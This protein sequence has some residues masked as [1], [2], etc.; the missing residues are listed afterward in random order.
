[1]RFFIC[2]TLVILSHYF[3]DVLF[4][5]KY[6]WRAFEFALVAGHR[7]V[8]V[9]DHN[10]K[11]WGWHNKIIILISV[12]EYKFLQLEQLKVGNKQEAFTYSEAN[13]IEWICKLCIFSCIITV[14]KFLYHV[15]VNMSNVVKI[16]SHL[17]RLHDI[18]IFAEVSN[19]DYRQELGLVGL[20]QDA[21]VC[22]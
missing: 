3:L 21:C 22:S 1:M 11:R 19:A 20:V 18:T 10:K 14:L 17:M 12:L 5:T 8:Y 13:I 4:F 16:T 6:S 7:R 9:C 2:K 15:F